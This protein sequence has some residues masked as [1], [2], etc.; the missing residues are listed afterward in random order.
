MGKSGGRE[1]SMAFPVE[2]RGITRP[3]F[4]W[5]EKSFQVDRA[6]KKRSIHLSRNRNSLHVQKR[7]KLQFHLGPRLMVTGDVL[8]KKKQKFF[9]A[10]VKENIPG[11]LGST[12]NLKK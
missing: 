8:E 2:T 11:G 12:P 6:L 3:L 4:P 7:N 10:R 1:K 9:G 5:V